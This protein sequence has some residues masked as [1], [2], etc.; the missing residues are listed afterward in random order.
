MCPSWLFGPGNIWHYTVQITQFSSLS[1]FLSLLLPLLPRKMYRL[2]IATFP[3]TQ[4]STHTL[5]HSGC[6]KL[7]AAVQVERALRVLDGAVALFDAVAG[8]EPQSETVWRQVCC[9]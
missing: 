7:L 1:L 4:R 6:I 2:D 9:P 3:E 8:V 5:C